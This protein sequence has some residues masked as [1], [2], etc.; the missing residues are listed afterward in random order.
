MAEEVNWSDYFASIV[1]VCPWSQAYWKRSRLDIQD[2]N[3]TILPLGKYVA[4]IY[5]YPGATD[6]ELEKLMKEFNQTRE[7]EEW[8]Y[9]HPQ[10]G[11]KSTPMP[12]L[13]QQDYDVLAKARDS[14][15]NTNNRK[16]GKLNSKL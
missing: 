7:E 15:N 9:S 2:W 3:G 1:G 12:C 5:Q 14:I 13:I 10:W 8:L 4:R 6:A 16:I 11:G